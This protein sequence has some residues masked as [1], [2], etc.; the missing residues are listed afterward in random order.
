VAP[1]GVVENSM[2]QIALTR[3]DI[4]QTIT[5][6]IQPD[7]ADIEADTDLITR[8]LI[9]LV[10]N[11]I[12]FTPSDG[13]IVI[14]VG[15]YQDDQHGPGDAWVLF[16]VSDNGPGVPAEDQERIFSKFGQVESHK[17]QRA[18][19]TGLGLTFCKLAVEAHGGRIWVESAPGEGSSFR[20]VLPPHTSSTNTDA[21]VEGASLVS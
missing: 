15:R 12:K 11:A 3:L 2:D 5:K 8:V 16:A 4:G 14:D 21:D 7:L 9:N 18:I 10:G 6:H 13:E 17:S 20:F 1:F 19:S